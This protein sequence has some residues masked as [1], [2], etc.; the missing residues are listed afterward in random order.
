MAL[1]GLIRPLRTLIKAIM[2]LLLHHC[3]SACPYVYM[4]NGGAHK[5]KAI[6]GRGI[7][8]QVQ[9]PLGTGV[10]HLQ[11][12]AGPQAPL[13]SHAALK[14]LAKQ[15]QARELTELFFREQEIRRDL[16]FEGQ[17]H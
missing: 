9:L 15:W 6:N 4:G 11:G 12:S 5:C 17:R 10:Q 14:K 2:L 13:T 8:E 3:Q 16:L 1:G 7:I